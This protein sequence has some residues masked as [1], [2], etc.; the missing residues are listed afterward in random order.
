MSNHKARLRRLEARHPAIC[1]A[2]VQDGPIQIIEIP[3]SQWE[4]RRSR[5]PA[6][7][8]GPCKLC[9]EFHWVPITVIEVKVLDPEPPAAEDTEALNA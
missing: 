2:S 5:A 8:P 6:G 3:A 7:P 4:D 9:G 1:P